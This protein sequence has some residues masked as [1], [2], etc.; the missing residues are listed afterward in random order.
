MQ[1]L[2]GCGGDRVLLYCCNVSGGGFC[3]VFLEAGIEQCIA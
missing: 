1:V 3:A 2:M